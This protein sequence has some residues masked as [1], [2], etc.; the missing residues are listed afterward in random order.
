MK[1]R[2]CARHADHGRPATTAWFGVLVLAFACGACSAEVTTPAN[3]TD[4]GASSSSSGGSS[5][6]TS[7]SGADAGASSG[8]T[9]S[10]GADAGASSGGTSSSGADTGASSGGTSSGGTSSGGNAFCTDDSKGSGKLKTPTG[11]GDHTFTATLLAC[12]LSTAEVA[13]CYGAKHQSKE[14]VTAT[15]RKMTSNAIPDHDADLFPNAGNPNAVKAQS[16]SYTVT[17]TPTRN[18][19]SK[20][21]QIIGYANNGIKFE[22]ETAER[23]KDGQWKYEALTWSGRLKADTL[24]KPGASLGLDCNF[25]HVQPNGEYHYHGAPTGLMPEKPA[26]T[27]LGWAADGFPILGRWGYSKAGDDKSGLAEM[28]GSYVLKSGT[29]QALDSNDS[30]P[31]GKYDG[32]F[33]Q[34]WE[35]KAGSGDLDECNGRQEKVTIG[36]KAYEYAYYLTWDYPWMPRCLWGDAGIGFKMGPPG[37]GGGPGG[38]KKPPPGGGG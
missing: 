27:H 30:P 14:I 18:K 19:D 37:G 20:W 8:G 1:Q 38:G 23:F 11:S 36:G 28:K 7:S 17:M 25:A 2:L 35:Y 15:E 5:S 9:S 32:T 24:K 4:A 29:R 6:G 10:S 3:G 12:S 31:P 21:A 16:K 33:V 34:D 26:F 22:P 13:T